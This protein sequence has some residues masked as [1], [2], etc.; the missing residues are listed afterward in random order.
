MN[1]VE[2]DRENTIF[3][4]KKKEENIPFQY[5]PDC[6][7]IWNNLSDDA[8]YIELLNNPYLNRESDVFDIKF[9]KSDSRGGF[10]FPITLLESEETQ[11]KQLL[12]YM[13]V[14]YKVLLKNMEGEPTG[15]L[16]DNYKDAFILAVHKE[17]VPSFYIEEYLISLASYGFYKYQGENKN[18]FPILRPF[19]KQTKVIHLEKSEVDNFKCDYV[20]DLLKFRLCTTSDFITR[21]VLV[22]Q[23]VELYISGIHQKSLDD[24]IE[25]YKKREL[26]RN[27]FSEKLKEISRESYQIKELMKDFHEENVCLDYKRAVMGLFNDISYQPKNETISTLIYTLRNQLFHSYGMFAGHEDA[28]NYV[29]FYFERVILML[30]RKKMIII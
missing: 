27:D 6:K 8:F 24:N 14:A 16:S 5:I 10:L 18:H 9:D 7:N 25:K 4:L 28:L 23:V 3:Y 15:V 11:N 17:T 13:F 21:F 1:N 30:L 22:Y 2:F 20:Q 29:I 19:N 26:N 12:S